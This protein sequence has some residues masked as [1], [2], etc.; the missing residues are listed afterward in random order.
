MITKINP[1]SCSPL[2]LPFPHFTDH[3]LWMEQI[4]GNNFRSCLCEG[5]EEGENPR[6]GSTPAVPTLETLPHEYLPPTL[7]QEPFKLPKLLKSI[8]PEWRKVLITILLAICFTWDEP[9]SLEDRDV[10]WNPGS[11]VGWDLGGGQV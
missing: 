6:E 3:Y 2:H 11:G 10:L 1:E 4:D 8:F 9:S 7:W 5:C